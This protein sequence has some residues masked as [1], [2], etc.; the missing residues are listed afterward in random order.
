[1]QDE[2]SEKKPE[3]NLKISLKDIEIFDG[4]T[5]DAFMKEIFIRCTEDRKRALDTYDNIAKR[6]DDDDD[7]FMIGDKANPYLDLSVKLNDNLI[8]LLSASQK[9]VESAIDAKDDNQGLDGDS[10][11][12]MLDKH[13]ILPAGMKNRKS[14]ED[15]EDEEIIKEIKEEVDDMSNN[16]FIIDLPEID[17]FEDKDRYK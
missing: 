16:R 7:V 2:N 6:F 13:D 12:D 3:E 11:L 4:M 5:Y 10:I 1:M 14:E 9:I 15:E 8:K 17:E